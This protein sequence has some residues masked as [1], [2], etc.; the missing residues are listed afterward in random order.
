MLS[1]FIKT[2][3]SFLPSTCPAEPDLVDS[4]WPALQAPAVI[5][6][7]P[8]LRLD[9]VVAPAT[10]PPRSNSG[11]PGPRC[12]FREILS[13]IEPWPPPQI[14]RGERGSENRSGVESGPAGML[15]AKE[16]ARLMGVEVRCGKHP[17]PKRSRAIVC[18]KRGSYGQLS[19][20]V[21][22]E[23]CK[24][25]PLKGLRFHRDAGGRGSGRGGGL[26]GSW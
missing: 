12:G 22:G 9:P 17:A 20:R 4:A 13:G 11:Q 15:R 10:P 2:A 8:P 5:S 18:T 3:S 19:S 6:L 23:R 24:L 16:F 1:S 21:G 25:R 14:E 7:I 26:R